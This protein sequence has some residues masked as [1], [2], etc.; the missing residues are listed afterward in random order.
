MKSSLHHLQ[1]GFTLIELMIVIAIIGILAA[2]ALPAYHD[3]T[4]RSKISEPILVASQCRNNITETAIV[5][6]RSAPTENSFGCGEVGSSDEYKSTYVSAIATTETGEIHVTVANVSPEVNDKEIIFIPYSDSARTVA[7]TSQDF[8]RGY[9]KPVRAW[10]CG[11][12]IDVKYLPSSCR[13][14]VSN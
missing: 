7:M 11:S 1:A 5:G 3:Y 12:E 2:V 13:D 4:I 10:S 6:R 14:D 8:V 9:L